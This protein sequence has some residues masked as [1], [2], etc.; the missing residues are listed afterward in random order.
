MIRIGT[1]IEAKS[2][3]NTLTRKIGTAANPLAVGHGLR[4]TVYAGRFF[5]QDT[6]SRDIYQ[7]TQDDLSSTVKIIMS[8]AEKESSVAAMIMNF[9]QFGSQTL[10]LTPDTAKALLWGL[11]VLK[12]GPVE[13]IPFEKLQASPVTT[14]E[15]M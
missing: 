3:S 15:G 8:V 5:I 10:T 9:V 14:S 12:N 1:D 13:R 11:D 7:M 4:L 6:V 2:T